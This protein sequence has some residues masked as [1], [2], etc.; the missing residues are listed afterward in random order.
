MYP[1][2]KSFIRYMICRYFL[3]FCELSF[4]FLDSSFLQRK[5]LIWMELMKLIF[6]F[7]TCALVSYLVNLRLI[8]GAKEYSCFLLEFGLFRSF[9]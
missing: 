5:S 3:P 4:H 8:Q 1:S 9:G 6:S 7:V 2:S